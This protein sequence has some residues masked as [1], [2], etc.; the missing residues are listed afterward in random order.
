MVRNCEYQ[1]GMIV[2]AM[3]AGIVES[4]WQEG[5]PWRDRFEEGDRV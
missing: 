3:S 2:V 4:T 1:A 5:V